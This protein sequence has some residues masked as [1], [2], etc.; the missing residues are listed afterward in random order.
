MAVPWYQY[1]S[2]ETLKTLE[3]DAAIGRSVAEAA[4]RQDRYGP[5]ELV[6]RGG[7]TRWQI[8]LDQLKGVLTLI[9]VGAAL[10]SIFLQEYVDLAF[11]LAVVVVNAVLGYV[12]E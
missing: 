3:T 12:Q 10:V 4:R 8:L 5:N 7:R 1:R 11:I 2:D 9:L 6:E